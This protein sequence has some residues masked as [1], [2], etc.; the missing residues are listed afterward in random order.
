M[1]LGKT[2]QTIALLAYL[3]ESRAEVGPHFVV[4]PK[5]LV[6]NWARELA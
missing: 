3:K 1:G 2:L 6:G 5:S 4:A